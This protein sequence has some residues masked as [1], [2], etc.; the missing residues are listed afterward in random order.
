MTSTAKLALTVATI[1]LALTGHAQSQNFYQSCVV[2][3][4]SAQQVAVFYQ[5][6][7]QAVYLTTPPN[8]QAVPVLAGGSPN[9]SPDVVAKMISAF[10]KAGNMVRSVDAI[11]DKSV[12]PPTMVVNYPDSIFAFDQPNATGN[13]WQLPTP[14]NQINPEPRLQSFWCGKNVYGFIGDDANPDVP[15]AICIGPGPQFVTQNID[16]FGWIATRNEVPI[17]TVPTAGQ[18]NQPPN[19][20]RAIMQNANLHTRIGLAHGVCNLTPAECAGTTSMTDLMHPIIGWEAATWRRALYPAQLI[21]NT[22]YFLRCAPEGAYRCGKSYGLLIR[23]GVQ[24]YPYDSLDV[25]KEGSYQLD[26]ILFS[27][28][29]TASIVM[30]EDLPAA[31]AANNTQ[32]AVAGNYVVKA[33][34]VQ[35][36]RLGRVHE[37]DR[38]ESRTAIALTSSGELWIVVVQPGH[39]KRDLGYSASDLV[40]YLLR[41][42][43][44]D[45]IMLDGGG[46]SQLSC[47]ICDPSAESVPGDGTGY[48]AIP[49]ALAIVG[50][51]NPPS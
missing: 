22:S 16:E 42:G 17:A 9:V 27:K 10:L 44:S 19:G 36:D 24:I 49:A 41:L 31:L 8:N 39:G 21:V 51:I 11:P 3:R 46:S 18:A 7:Q 32:N 43:A 5:Q 13:V 37:G 12:V 34:Q 48:R 6:Y 33:G 28:T 14:K 20:Y 1:G 38:N 29:G 40:G 50:G 47:L 30:Y 15:V 45:I 23:D 26:A 25:T 35:N 2:E 4:C